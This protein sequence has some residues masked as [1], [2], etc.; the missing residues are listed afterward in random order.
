MKL[1]YRGVNYE[2]STPML[3]VME[4]DI[5][6][7]YRGQNWKSHYLRHIPEPAPVSNLKYRGVAYCTGKPAVAVSSTAA[8]CTLPAFHKREREK[9]LNQLTRTHLT[10]IRNSL[11]RRMQ[12]AQ[13]NGDEKLVNLLKQEKMAFP[14]Q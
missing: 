6:G 14:L 13:A 5:G 3:E 1:S 9:E 10:N 4:G 2:N 7:T 8:R 12:I 11:E